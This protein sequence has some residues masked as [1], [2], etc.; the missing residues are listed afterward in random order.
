MDSK[1][2][3]KSAILNRLT[4]LVKNLRIGAT[5]TKAAMHDKVYDDPPLVEEELK[6]LHSEEGNGR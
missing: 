3:K 4:A 1:R 6:A 5:L 2:D